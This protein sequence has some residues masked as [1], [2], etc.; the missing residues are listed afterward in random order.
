[1]VRRVWDSAIA[2]KV[3]EGCCRVCGGYP[4]D[5]AHVVGRSRDR[6]DGNKQ[7]VDPDSVV[8]L[9]RECHAAYDRHEKDLL[10]FLTVAEQA[11]AVLDAGGMLSAYRRVTG[12]R[13]FCDG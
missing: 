2:K 1:M 11:R 8:P 9:C 5:A 4:V 13:G 7:I 10:P 3:D 12:T 6:R